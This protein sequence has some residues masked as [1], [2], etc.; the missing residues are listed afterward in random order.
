MIT[1]RQR[2]FR[3]MTGSLDSFIEEGVRRLHVRFT[4]DLEQIAAIEATWQTSLMRE[5][6]PITLDFW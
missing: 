1:L 6:T 2:Q 4:D 5:A 3:D